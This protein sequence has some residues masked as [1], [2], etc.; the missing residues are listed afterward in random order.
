MYLYCPLSTF[1][2][3]SVVMLECFVQQSYLVICVKGY[4]QSSDIGI[5]LF[6]TGFWF[7]SAGF[8]LNGLYF[9]K[10]SFHFDCLG[11]PHK[12]MDQY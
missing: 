8:T 6:P 10:K 9:L 4:R 2:P 11:L 12:R 1:G 5:L 7:K 3:F